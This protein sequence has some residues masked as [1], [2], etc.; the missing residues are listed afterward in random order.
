VWEPD[1][2]VGQP[3]LPLEDQRTRP[4]RDL[5]PTRPPRAVLMEA[6]DVLY[7][8]RG[9][10]HMAETGSS[11]PGAARSWNQSCTE[12]AQIARLGPTL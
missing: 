1:P 6:G 5:V 7:M 9:F 2:A 3:A 10:A 11:Q 12:L 8:P 4:A